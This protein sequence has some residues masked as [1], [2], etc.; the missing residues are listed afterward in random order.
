MK[1]VIIGA[2]LTGS[3]A[4]RQLAD[5]GYKV[6]IYEKKPNVGG[7]VY[8]FLN[9]D[10]AYTHLYGPHIF[11]TNS[12]KAYEFIS[13][14]GKWNEYRHKV[15]AK[16]K[17]CLCPLPFNF[18]SIDLCF[19]LGTAALYKNKLSAKYGSNST[20]TI[21]E[22]ISDTDDDLKNLADFVYE[23]VF[24]HYTQKQWGMS[25]HEL[26]GDVMKRVPIRVSYEDGYFNDK[27]QLIPEEGYTKVIESILSHKNITVVCDYDADRHISIEDNLLL[28]DGQAIDYPFIYTGC[29]DK[30]FDYRFG[31]LPYRSL[32]FDFSEVEWQFQPVSVVNYPNEHDYTRITEFGHFYPGRNYKTST[33]LY[34]YPCEYKISSELEPYYPIPN[35]QNDALYLKY[36]D[37]ACCIPNLYLAGRLGSYKYINMDA[38]VLN[39]L[40][41]A[42]HAANSLSS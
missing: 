16:I 33:L 24:L 13:R 29:P 39:G 21:G 40:T 37:L 23:N 1:V 25:P 9:R 4:A 34:E 22:L 28:W 30:L 19:D 3:A 5:S 17:D 11:H 42:G 8:D 27:Y 36:A 35:T 20:V 32:R 6:T 15:L 31:E 41:I 38:A 12:Q 14:F 7:S 10:G 26:G 18:L 2:G